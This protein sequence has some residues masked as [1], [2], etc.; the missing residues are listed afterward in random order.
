MTHFH[1]VNFGSSTITLKISMSGMEQNSLQSFGATKTTLTSTNVMDEN[2]FQ[3]P[4]KVSPV[5]TI[6]EQVSKNMDVVLSPNTENK[7][8]LN[9]ARL[10]IE[11]DVDSP[12]PD[13]EF[14]MTDVYAFNTKEDRKSLWQHLE[15]NSGGINIPW[16]ITGDFNSVLHA[17]D[18]IGGLSVIMGEVVDFQVCIDVCELIELP[19]GRCRYIWNDK[20]GDNGVFSKID[21]AFINREWLDNMPVIQADFL[22]EGI[23][24]HCPLKL[25]KVTVTLKFKGIVTQVWQQQ[26]EGY[27]MFQIVKKLKIQKKALKKLNQQHFRNILAEA[28]DDRA[29]LSQ[30]Q[31]RLHVDPSSVTLQEQEK[32]MYQKFRKSSYLAK[33]FLQQRSKA[34]WS[35]L[36]DENTRYFYSVIKHKRLQQAITQI[37]DQTGAVQTDSISIANVLVDYYEAMLGKRKRRRAKAFHIFLKNGHILSTEQQV[38]LIQPFTTKEVKHAMFSIDVNKSLGPDEYDSGFYRETWSIIGKDITAAILEFMEN[39]RC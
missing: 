5:E 28:E 17:D 4:K 25:K 27:S 11:V 34:S 36:G 39:G 22:V 18:R 16:L 7:I 20:H 1:V 35:K 26:I 33:L 15:S 21:W 31:N 19:Y 38:E 12:L 3:D 29:V 9:F 2:Y 30:A 8:G 13:K 37:K 6:V 24:D 10:L 32:A 14:Y 23:N